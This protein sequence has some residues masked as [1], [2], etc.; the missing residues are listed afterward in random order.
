MMDEAFVSLFR[1][2]G[3]IFAIASM[4][5]E[6]LLLA[7]LLLVNREQALAA[8]PFFPD[9]F[10]LG[11]VVLLLWAWFPPR[12]SRQDNIQSAPAATKE[13]Q[14]PALNQPQQDEPTRAGVFIRD[15]QVPKEGVDPTNSDD[16]FSW[17]RQETLVRCA[18]ADGVSTS[19]LPAMWARIIVNHFAELPAE[20][21]IVQPAQFAAWLKEC[22]L[23]WHTWLNNT[24]IPNANRA[25]G[26]ERDWN[27]ERVRGAQSTFAACS[28]HLHPLQQT[29]TTNMQ[30][31]AIGDANVF[32]LHPGSANGVSWSTLSFPMS[33]AGDFGSTPDTL[34]TT[35]DTLHM[36]LPLL[37]TAVYPVQRGDMLL[38]ATD[39]LAKWILSRQE[40][41]QNPW[42]TLLAITDN[43]IFYRFVEYERQHDLE[44]DDTTMAVVFIQ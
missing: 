26:R 4:L 6:V 2:I 34:S 20:R 31:L 30:L 39:A 5:A 41:G 36:T 12:F 9:G 14:V 13:S 21:D 16:A 37:K 19:F 42:S 40:S 24:W 32:L 3:I 18:I 33:K 7:V 44:V 29:G 22:S 28:F 43:E 35:E 23:D 15:F 10:V 1:R 8:W 11:L 27:H 17:R 25:S 38:F